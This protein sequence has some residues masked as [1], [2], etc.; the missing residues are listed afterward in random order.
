MFLRKR[1]KKTIHSNDDNTQ[2]IIRELSNQLKDLIC[3]LNKNTK[4]AQCTSYFFFFHYASSSL[5]NCPFIK[6]NMI[7]S[8]KTTSFIQ[9]KH[10]DD[11]G[12]PKAFVLSLEF[13]LF[14]AFAL[15]DIPLLAG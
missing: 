6:Y 3:V 8:N 11:S 10:H 7:N 9:Q 13:A 15:G 5:I 14:Q 2:L 4:Q 1:K 12:L